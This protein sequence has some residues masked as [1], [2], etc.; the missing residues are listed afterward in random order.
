[1]KN[2]IGAKMKT[3]I[4]EPSLLFYGKVGNIDKY[5]IEQR[6]SNRG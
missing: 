4:Y 2:G 3:P 5:L 1:M 6:I